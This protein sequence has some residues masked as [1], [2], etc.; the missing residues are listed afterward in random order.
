MMPKTGPWLHLTITLH[1]LARPHWLFTSM[2]V[3]IGQCPA[4]PTVRTRRAI[5]T[6]S[7][8]SQEPN[9]CRQVSV[10]DMLHLG[11]KDNAPPPP[12]PRYHHPNPG[13]LRIYH[14]QHKRG[15][16]DMIRLR[17]FEMGRAAWVLQVG[18]RHHTGPYKWKREA[19]E[20]ESFGARG[21]LLPLLAL[22]ME[23]GTRNQPM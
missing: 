4:E 6:L 22:K 2:S 14:L 1:T 21:L 19:G 12:P 16:S 11:G 23:K 20:S 5:W 10:C 8:Q 9:Q 17:V 3:L 18:P 7:V 15:F 13:Y